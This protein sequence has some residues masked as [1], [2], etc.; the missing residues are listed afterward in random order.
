[1][2]DRNV[3][4]TNSI[5]H[6]MSLANKYPCI[7]SPFFPPCVYVS[8]HKLMPFKGTGMFSPVFKE[9]MTSWY[10]TMSGTLP[11]YYVDSLTL[12]IFFFF[13]RTVMPIL[14]TMT[15]KTYQYCIVSVFLSFFLS[16]LF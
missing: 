9:E 4:K 13:F 11:K 3:T 12:C 8:D 6:F 2:N 10:I 7:F 14:P 1:M 5:A 15:V 16:F